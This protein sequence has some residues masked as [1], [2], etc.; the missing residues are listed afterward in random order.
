MPRR[1]ILCLLA[2]T[3]YSA[4]A[5][6]RDVGNQRV[7]TALRLARRLKPR[8]SMAERT[9]LLGLVRD[10]RMS[11]RLVFAQGLLGSE[12]KL[13]L[14]DKLAI[15][16][17]HWANGQNRS[18]RKAHELRKFSR[19][20]RRLLMEMMPTETKTPKVLSV[21]TLGARKLLGAAG[22][23][24]SRPYYKLAAKRAESKLSAAKAVTPTDPS[25][26]NRFMR[27]ILS[28]GANYDPP[29]YSETVYYL[30]H[31]AGGM[32]VARPSWKLKPMAARIV[33]EYDRTHVSPIKAQSAIVTAKYTLEDAQA[34]VARATKKISAV[35]HAW[36][37]Q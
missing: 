7:Q 26:R 12:R 35:T 11:E 6:G 33:D 27:K 36:A 13:T 30:R 8:S 17:T 29:A 1:P 22:A 21:L 24:I 2:L 10:M 15:I 28:D 25:K 5:W 32:A 34:N 14:H 3:V 18:S 37:P 31:A 9:P 4:P 23:L 20:E 19:K 16:R